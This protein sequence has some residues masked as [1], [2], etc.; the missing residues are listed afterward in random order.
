MPEE[1]AHYRVFVAAP[2]GL[3][4]ERRT[5]AQTLNKYNEAEAVQRQAWFCP[6]GWEDTLAG[7]GRPQACINRDLVAEYGHFSGMHRA[8]V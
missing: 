1:V 4:Q 7:V 3:E 8:P 6:V 5:F 2:G